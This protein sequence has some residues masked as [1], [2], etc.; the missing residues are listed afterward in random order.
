VDRVSTSLLTELTGGTLQ[1][2]TRLAAETELAGRLGVR[3]STIRA[4]INALV[5]AGHLVRGRDDATY[6]AR[7]TDVTRREPAPGSATLT[8][9]HMGRSPHCIAAGPRPGLAPWTRS[10][11]P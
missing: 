2:G 1:P 7:A 5:A 8:R 9:S 6:V 4:A 10:R 3:C 11:R